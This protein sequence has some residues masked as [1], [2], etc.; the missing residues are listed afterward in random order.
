[1]CFSRQGHQEVSLQKSGRHESFGQR[2]CSYLRNTKNEEE[3]GHSRGCSWLVQSRVQSTD[4]KYR[5]LTIDLE[6]GRDADAVDFCAAA[7][8][9]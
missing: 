9:R 2:S 6:I 1:M 4:G 5:T 8:R 3:V 7:A